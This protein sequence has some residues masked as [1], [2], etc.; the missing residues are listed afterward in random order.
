MLLILSTLTGI[1]VWLN[2]ATI[3]AAFVGTIS[4][5]AVYL[6]VELYRTKPE[7]DNSQRST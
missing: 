7:P 3:E 5:M 2:L 1:T 6:A 4:G